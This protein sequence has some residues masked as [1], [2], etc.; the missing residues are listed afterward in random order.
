MDYSRVWKFGKLKARKQARA[1]KVKENGG[2]PQIQ[3]LPPWLGT[4]YS[5]NGI[6]DSLINL[7]IRSRKGEWVSASRLFPERFYSIPPNRSGGRVEVRWKGT[8]KERI[9]FRASYRGVLACSASLKTV[10]NVFGDYVASWKE[11]LSQ[12]AFSPTSYTVCI[13]WQVK[14]KLQCKKNVF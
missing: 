5:I 6:I 14:D 4:A 3:K 11:L 9:K 2:S 8:K 12:R 10:S 13:Q 7:S 1:S